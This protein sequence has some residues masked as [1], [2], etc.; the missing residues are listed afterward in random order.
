M[1]A[2]MRIID[3]NCDCV[4]SIFVLEN[5]SKDNTGAILAELQA[6]Y[7]ARVRLWRFPGLA[8][9]QPERISRLAWCRNFLLEQI[10][11]EVSNDLKTYFMCPSTLTVK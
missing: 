10:R 7:P 4:G 6:L 9:A 1:N 2:L 11:I 5:D 8:A 3:A